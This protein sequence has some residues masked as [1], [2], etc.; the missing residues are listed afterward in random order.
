MKYFTAENLPAYKDFKYWF[1]YRDHKWVPVT[2]YAQG[3]IDDTQLD[4]TVEEAIADDL[5]KFKHRPESLIGL[6]CDEIY[7][8]GITDIVEIYETLIVG[9][10]LT[11]WKLNH[12]NED[13]DTYLPTAMRCLEWLRNTDF[14]EAPGSSMYH[15]S[16]IHGLL[17]HSLNVLNRGL[18]LLSCNAFSAVDVASFELCALCHDWCKIGLY[19]VYQKNVKDEHTGKWTSQNAYRTNQTGIPLGHGASSMFLADRFFRL[20][21][22]EALAIRWH[23]GHWRVCDSEVNELQKANEEYPLVHLLQ[24]AD[25]LAIVKY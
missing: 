4:A 20:K 3:I 24:F 14:Y 5:T 7:R 23:M 13:P 1:I 25:Q 9:L 6:T 18:D 12:P 8:R 16:V 15:D 19:E 21:A 22:D 11:R 2:K 10:M 17:N